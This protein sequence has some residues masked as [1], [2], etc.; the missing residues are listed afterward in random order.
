M[1][2]NSWGQVMNIE[3][4]RWKNRLIITFSKEDLERQNLK[5]KGFNSE[6]Q[7]R[8]LKLISLSPK[9][10]STAIK[11]RFLLIGK[12]G[13]IK[14]QSNQPFKPST[15]FELIDSMPMRQQEMR[16]KSGKASNI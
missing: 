7:D 4:Y 15:I 10:K 6:F 9:S 11:K 16:K 5:L 12:D 1:L 14:L 13:T 8:D 3:Q 2:V